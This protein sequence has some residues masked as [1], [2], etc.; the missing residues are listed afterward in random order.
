MRL[1]CGASTDGGGFGTLLGLGSEPNGWS[2]CAIGHTRIGA[3]DQGGI[4]FLTR[5][6]ADNSEP[7]KKRGVNSTRSR[8]NCS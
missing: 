2:K 6:T 1:S 4:V 5:A 7:D 3:Y 8:I